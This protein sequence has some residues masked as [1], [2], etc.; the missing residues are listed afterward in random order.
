MVGVADVESNLSEEK[1]LQVDIAE[2]GKV[3]V[4]RT[5]LNRYWVFL[6][7]D[8]QLTPPPPPPPHPLATPPTPR[9]LL[10]HAAK[11]SG[12]FHL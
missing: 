11:Q 2:A 9:P 6:F 7:F 10:L 3:S 1:L 5:T 4:L 8:A 12:V